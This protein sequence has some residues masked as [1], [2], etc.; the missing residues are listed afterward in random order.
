MGRVLASF[1]GCPE[2]ARLETICHGRNAPQRSIERSLT[3]MAPTLP[4]RSTRTSPA[5]TLGDC[6]Q[7]THFLEI[8]HAGR[9]SF[10]SR[11]LVHAI[12]ASAHG[13]LA[14]GAPRAGQWCSEGPLR[15]YP[16]STLISERRP[17]CRDG[18][19]EDWLRLP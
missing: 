18:Q 8:W 11:H 17:A 15:A 3:L 6:N 12:A 19:Q 16:S 1:A 13:G 2:S 9:V 10:T 7:E 5:P 14:A 4:A